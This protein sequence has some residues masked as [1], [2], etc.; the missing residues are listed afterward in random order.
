MDVILRTG[1]RNPFAIWREG[2]SVCIANVNR[3]LWQHRYPIGKGPLPV[4][5]QRE[6]THDSYQSDDGGF[7]STHIV[8]L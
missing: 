8:H 7:P 3:V 2:N 6:Y 1:D 4:V 5:C